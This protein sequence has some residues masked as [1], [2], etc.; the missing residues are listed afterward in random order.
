MMTTAA[1]KEKEFIL[2]NERYGLHEDTIKLT[3]MARYDLLEDRS[4]EQK[5][6]G[7]LP[8]W[9]QNLITRGDVLA[10]GH[11]P[12]SKKLKT[13]EYFEFYSGLMNHPRLLETMKRLGY[14]GQ[15]VLHQSF[16]AN[17]SDFEDNEVWE[18]LPCPAD[19]NKV[20]SESKL[21][22]TDYSSSILDFAWMDKPV[23]YTQ[24]DCD[25]FYQ[26][27]WDGPHFDYVNEGFG[28]VCYDL[29]SSV[30]TIIEILENNCQMS[31]FYQKRSDDYFTFRD[32]NNCKR[33]N[34]A[35]LLLGD[36]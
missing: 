3:G 12:Y 5:I 23:V 10:T 4:Q 7:L 13:S 16:K 29:E 28:P 14:K 6:I 22:V 26:I 20:F 21:V 36:E 2:S 33:I 35:I 1:Q 27:G 32:R 24:F 8:T 18:I 34:Q 9:R 19:Y 25:T 15:F 31:E 17:H 11:Y 30:D